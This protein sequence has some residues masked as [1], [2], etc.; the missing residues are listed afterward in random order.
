LVTGG[1]GGLGQATVRH[2]AERGARVVIVDLAREEGDA[3]AEELGS[4][5]IFVE[6]DAR[7]EEDV[8][9]ALERAA[10][11]GP[12][13]IAV[14][15]HGGFSAGGRTVRPDGTPHNL[16]DYRRVLD[17]YLVGTFNV[18]RLAA[19][20][21]SRTEPAND[22]GERGVIITTSS[23]AGYEGTIGQIAYASAKG[24]VIGMTLTGARDLA[25]TGVRV[26]S[27]APGPFGTPAYGVAP[28]RMDEL[29]G[30][31]VPF[32]RRLGRPAEFAQLVEAICVNTY[33]NGDVM[34]IDGAIRF[35]PKSP[36]PLPSPVDGR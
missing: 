11:L 26:M 19:A 33:L 32:P 29:W 24:G 16:D 10:T 12:V 23:I 25:V 21:I 15:A 27:I 22:D 35:G 7:S 8:T 14:C 34:R 1:A 2:L 28:E 17:H 36:P 4:S 3:L 9:A 6:A 31:Y 30:S 5:A 20:T 18:L 13:R